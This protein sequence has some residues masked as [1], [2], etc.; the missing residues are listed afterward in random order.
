MTIAETSNYS[1]PE[2]AFALMGLPCE[3]LSSEDSD[4]LRWQRGL[5]RLPRR[6]YVQLGSRAERLRGSRQAALEAHPARSIV[7]LC[8]CF[9][10][11]ASEKPKCKVRTKKAFMEVDGK[12]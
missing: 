1:L 2:P 3:G 9:D 7:T 6:C 8:V 10:N 11:I 5:R 12:V 4:F